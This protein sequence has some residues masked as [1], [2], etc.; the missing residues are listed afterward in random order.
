[1][2]RA[3]RDIARV[4]GIARAVARHGVLS[5]LAKL[6]IAHRLGYAFT[7]TRSVP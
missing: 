5:P 1:M 2:L 4:A 3:V 6:G 7:P